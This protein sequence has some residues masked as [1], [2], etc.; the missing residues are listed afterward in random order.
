MTLQEHK[1]SANKKT[2][3]RYLDGFRRGDH[4]QILSCL[5]EDVIWELPGAFYLVGKQQFDKEIENP[6]FQGLPDI[7]V[8]R[9]TEENDVVIVEG[10]V[11]AQKADGECL[12][13][14]F[15]DVFEMRAGEI[16][17]IISYLMEV[18]ADGA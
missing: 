11:R 17:R 4:V 5:T 14:A 18:T 13:L 2:V 8:S 6:A 3:A 1:M 16:C 10:M 7:A 12:N 9:T 15:V